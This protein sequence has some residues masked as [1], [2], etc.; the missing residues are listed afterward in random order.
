[1]NGFAV[2]AAAA[3]LAGVSSAQQTTPPSTDNTQRQEM[4]ERRKM[5]HGEAGKGMRHGRFGRRG[6]FGMLR[7]IQLTDDQ[8]AQLKVIHESNKPSEGVMQEMRSLMEAK[9]AG[10]MT[11]VQKARM[12]ELREQGKLRHQAV[13]QQVLSLLTPEQKQQLEARKAE[14][15]QRREEFRQKR[16]QWKQQRQQKMQQTPASPATDNQ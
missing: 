10:T 14:R 3:V 7:G 4:R 16:E 5:R 6:G 8:K 1:M 2:M 15:K 12:A 11:D 13:N 9:R